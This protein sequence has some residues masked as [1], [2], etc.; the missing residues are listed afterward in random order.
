MG[1]K[2]GLESQVGKGSRF[3]FAVSF[4]VPQQMPVPELRQQGDSAER[5]MSGR[6]PLRI[7]VAEDNAVNRLVAIRFL[8]KM[9][10]W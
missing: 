6:A 7:L 9:A 10:T 2:I 1:G 5:Q 3:H 8:E 4:G